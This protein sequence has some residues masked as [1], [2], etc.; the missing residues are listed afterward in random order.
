M[1]LL[2]TARFIIMPPG[3]G[4]KDP[5]VRILTSQKKVENWRLIKHTITKVAESTISYFSPY[6]EALYPKTCVAS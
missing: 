6:F 3:D 1:L 2:L 4:K 5:D